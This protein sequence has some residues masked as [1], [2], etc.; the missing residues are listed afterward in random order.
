MLPPFQTT[1]ARTRHFPHL[2]NSS[3]ISAA[4]N[5]NDIRLS[6]L[7]PNEQKPYISLHFI[8]Q[9]YDSNFQPQ[10]VGGDL[11]VV[12]YQTYL[13]SED[14]PLANH[15]NATNYY[16]VFKSSSFTT[17]HL[18]GTYSA[19]LFF[20]LNILTHTT[21]KMIR[22]RQCIYHCGITILVTRG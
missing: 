4:T 13:K 19:N 22:R 12:D 5:C 2:S 6:S 9:T 14:A 11:F 1:H 17:D 7:L 3:T 10:H 18:N 21:N 8:F 16:T 20:P 15:D